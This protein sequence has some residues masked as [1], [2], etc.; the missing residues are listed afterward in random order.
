[1]SSIVGEFKT[2]ESEAEPDSVQR[3][4]GS[5]LLSGSM[6]IDDAVELLGL[7]LD[8]GRNYSTV[9]GMMLHTMQRLPGVG[10]SVDI[11]GWRIEVMDL[12]GRRI[13]KVLAQRIARNLRLRS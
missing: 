5:W 2:E 7:K 10:E 6:K 1:M 9:A 8:P 4:D 3:D 13:D 11:S 12:D